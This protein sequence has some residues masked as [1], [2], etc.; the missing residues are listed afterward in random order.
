MTTLYISS[1]GRALRHGKHLTA[2][3]K[4]HLPL[5]VKTYISDLLMA[6]N[7][8]HFDILAYTSDKTCTSTLSSSILCYKQTQP[9]RSIDD[10]V[11]MILFSE[12]M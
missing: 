4:H 2:G 12:I 5:L 8:W 11:E 1:M 7:S 10:T 6:V 3:Q 9:V